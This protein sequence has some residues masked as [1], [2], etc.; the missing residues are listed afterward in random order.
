MTKYHIDDNMKKHFD[1][2]LRNTD[3]ANRIIREL[4]DFTSPRETTLTKE[5]VTK[6]ID[7]VC[8]LVKPRCS[9]QNII[10]IKEICGDIPLLSINEKKLEEAFMNFVSNAV[11]AMSEGGTLTIRTS[12]AGKFVVIDFTDTG[13]GI[14]EDN[15]D[16]IFEPF[17]TTK[18][19]GTGLGLSLAYHNV[20]AHSGELLI[21]S[22]TGIG[23]TVS[24]K[25]PII[26]KSHN[27]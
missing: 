4:L 25:L 24:V 10:L 17:F 22:K 27:N 6:V 2:I 21:K 1:V 14:T 8:E 15:L 16:K 13:C 3:S 19:D 26:N 5:D 20:S 12:I 18:D 11:E 23:T 7:H 9:K